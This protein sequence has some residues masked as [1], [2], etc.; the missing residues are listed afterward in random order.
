MGGFAEYERFDALGLAELVR[1]GET[2]AEELLDEAVARAEA[3]NPRINAI[4]LPMYE[5][6]RAAIAAG[7]PHGPFTGVPFLLK[8]LHA[9]YGGVTTTHG[10]GLFANAVADH[11]TD[12][13]ARYKQAGLVIFGKTNTPELGLSVSTEPRLFGPCRNPWSLD[14]TTG[15]SSGGAGAAV[16]A[17]VLPAAHASDG[18]GSI[19]IPASCCGLFGLKPTRGRSP[20]GP[21]AGEGWSGMSAQ[22]VVSLTVRD[23]AALLDA[24]HEP[25][26]GDPYAAPQTERP[27][28]DEVGADPGRLR[29]ALAIE[30]ASGVPVDPECEGAARDAARLCEELG[31]DVTETG[32]EVD[33]AALRQSTSVI[34]G[35]NV[36]AMI[37]ARAQE[38][39]RELAQDDVELITWALHQLGQ[40][41]TA[42]DYANAVK[43]IH[44]IGRRIGRFFEDYDVLITPMLTREPIKIGVLDM[45]TSDL[46][47]YL[48]ALGAFTAYSQLY[49]AT[50][51]PAMSV[52]LHWTPAGLPVGVHCVSRF[53]DEAT[54]FR[55][56]TQ[57]ESAR[58]WF[59]RKPSL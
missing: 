24:I 41:S 1:K 7:L 14:H 3:I 27:F 53:G 8:D 56:A 55:L 34:I 28:L 58:P 54:L 26:V 5:R 45:M 13:V 57:I 9:G 43:G 59:E 16:A 23:S 2:S 39:G 50:G 19:R 51:Q 21:D 48:E 52:P 10:C 47:G 25:Q 12:L 33:A 18:G 22:H 17:R 44:L 40:G 46:P 37:T 38:L 11:D 30:P 15:G 42:V 31:H 49:N 29:I 32:P 36:S 35:A 4:V 20:M 6:A